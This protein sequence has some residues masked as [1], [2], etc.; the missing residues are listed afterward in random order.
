MPACR[1]PLMAIGT[2]RMATQFLRVPRRGNR[3][4]WHAIAICVFVFGG[5]AWAQDATDPAQV[6]VA[7]SEIVVRA[8]QL[9][10]PITVNGSLDEAVYSQVS[11]I[12]GFIQAEPNAGL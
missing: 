2:R 4:A 1:P 8:V 10:E 3:R 7:K 11:P 12:S 6:A 9:T 5:R